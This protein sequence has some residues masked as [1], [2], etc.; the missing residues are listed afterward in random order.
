MT[1]AARECRM[2]RAH[3]LQDS[4]H[5]SPSSS[6]LPSPLNDRVMIQEDETMHEN[7]SNLSVAMAAR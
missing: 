6:P 1:V 7:E 2:E 3:R 5:L 4:K